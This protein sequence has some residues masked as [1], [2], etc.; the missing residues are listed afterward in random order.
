MSASSP[1]RAGFEAIHQSP[2]IAFIEIAWRWTFG[3]VGTLLLLIGTKTFLAGLK[4]SEGDEQALR[5]HDPTLI[6]AALL[7]TLQ[8]PGV[9]ERFFA[10]IAAVAVPSVIVWII[11][12]ALG[13]T[14]VLRRLMPSA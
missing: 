14:A 7:H 1:I 12:A 11:V 9:I 5:G 13:R 2:A 6:A 10:I 3:L 4:L 8:Q